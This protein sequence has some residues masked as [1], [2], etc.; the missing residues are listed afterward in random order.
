MSRLRWF[1]YLIRM[2]FGSLPL[3]VLHPSPNKKSLLDR[4]KT[5]CRDYAIFDW[6]NLGISPDWAEDFLLEGGLCR[7]PP[8]TCYPHS[9]I[10]NKLKNN[11]TV[12]PEF[13]GC[14]FQRILNLSD[15][16][17][18]N[19]PVILGLDWRN[20]GH[21]CVQASQKRPNLSMVSVAFACSVFQMSLKNITT[22]EKLLYRQI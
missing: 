6:K 22:V 20:N 4:P 3:K 1:E 19:L 13:A 7:F 11:W 18:I 17:P 12:K 15:H 10:S 2:S 21:G 8:R 14:V 9:R 16:K 5:H